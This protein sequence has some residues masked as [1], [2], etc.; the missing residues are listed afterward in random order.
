M[1]SCSAEM[2]PSWFALYLEVSLFCSLLHLAEVLPGCYLKSPICTK[3]KG[4]K[5]TAEISEIK[6]N[7]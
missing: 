6:C 1:V 5:E 7:C 3:T 4:E 2:L